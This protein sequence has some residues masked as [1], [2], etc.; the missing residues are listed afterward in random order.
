MASSYSPLVQDAS[1][2]KGIPLDNLKDNNKPLT[3]DVVS[4]PISN[5]KIPEKGF[6]EVSFCIKQVGSYYK[7]ILSAFLQ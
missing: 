2:E 6:S 3:D 4:K 7:I 5:T 1:L